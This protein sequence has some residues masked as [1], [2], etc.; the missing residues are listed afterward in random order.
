M[1]TSVFEGAPPLSSVGTQG[2][3]TSVA[4]LP[5]L[6]PVAPS[7]KRGR[8]KRHARSLV[9]A[10]VTSVVIGGVAAGGEL[11]SQFR[12]QLAMSLGREPDNFSELYFTSPNALPS[13]YHSDRPLSVTFGVK[14]ISAESH[15]FRYSVTTQSG[16]ARTTTRSEGLIRVG[17]SEVA[18][19]TVTVRI[20][21]G[22]TA[23]TIALVGQPDAIRLLLHQDA[24]AQ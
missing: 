12:H 7:P 1:R 21:S 10:I 17:P 8:R 22:T 9:L 14:N 16:A 19:R 3:S 5:A 13:T 11:S 20:P 2:R 24:G 6:L 23:L 15:A 18:D 4:P